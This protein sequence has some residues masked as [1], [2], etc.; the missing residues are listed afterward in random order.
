MFLVTVVSLRVCLMFVSV[1]VVS[2]AEGENFS[3]AVRLKIQER[4]GNIHFSSF[5]LWLFHLLEADEWSPREQVSYCRIISIPSCSLHCLKLQD[6]PCIFLSFFSSL[7]LSQVDSI[8]PPTDAFTVFGVT[9]LHMVI[10]SHQ[11][12]QLHGVGKSSNCFLS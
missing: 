5:T 4:K 12:A 11:F 9:G 10:L 2:P 3:C 8:L 6:T 1:A 7:P